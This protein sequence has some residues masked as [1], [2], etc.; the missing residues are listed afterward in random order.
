M[1]KVGIIATCQGLTNGVGFCWRG[2]DIN[3][4]YDV[5]TYTEAAI[6]VDL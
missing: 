1:E 2:R 3:N 5:P 6:E 4:L